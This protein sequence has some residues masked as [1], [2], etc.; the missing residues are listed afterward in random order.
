MY[1]LLSADLVA[2]PG[3]PVIIAHA[4]YPAVFAW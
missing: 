1:V 3:D 2:T 4:P